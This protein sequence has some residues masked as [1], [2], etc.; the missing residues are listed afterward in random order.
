MAQQNLPKEHKNHREIL[1][2]IKKVDCLSDFFP[3][4]GGAGDQI[5]YELDLEVILYGRTYHHKPVGPYVQLL[6]YDPG[7][8]IIKQGDWADNYYYIVVDG[9]VE[10]ARRDPDGGE[11]ELPDL[12]KGEQFGARAM[13]AGDHYRVTV[14]A[15]ADQCVDILKVHRP[16]L[17]LLRKMPR[18]DETFKKSYQRH[19]LEAAVNDLMNKTRMGSELRDELFRIGS[20]KAFDKHHILFTEAT[21]SERLFLILEGWVRR[22]QRTEE[23]EVRDFLGKGYCLGLENVM[24]K[25]LYSATA[26]GRINVLEINLQARRGKELSAA[27]IPALK[28]FAAPDM[29]KAVD[30]YRP[31]M[32]QKILEAQQSLI[33]T[34]LVD[35][36]NLLIMDMD[37]CVRCGNCSMACQKVHGRSRLT[38]RGVHITRIEPAKLRSIQS[39]LAPSACMHCNDPECLMGCPTGAISRFEG[40]EIDIDRKTCIGCGDCATQCPYDAIFMINRNEPP[41]P[42]PVTLKTRLWSNLAGFREPEAPPVDPAKDMIAVKC[43]LCSDRKTLNPNENEP[44]QHVYSC[45]EN[46]PTGA[47]ARIIPDKDFWEISRIRNLKMLDQKHA[48]GRSIH[49]ADPAKRWIHAVCI[50]VFMLAAA[51]AILGLHN[52]GYGQRVLGFLNMRWITG[53]AGLVGIG[54]AGAYCWRR[55]IYDKRRWPLRYW[56]LIHYYFGVAACFIILLH[57]GTFSGGWLTTLLMVSFDVV[58][59]TGVFGLACYQIIPR[60]LTRIEGVPLLLEDLKGRREELRKELSEIIRKSPEHLR[61]MLTRRVSRRCNSS[62]AM[63]HVLAQES[64]GQLLRSMTRQSRIVDEQTNEE[65]RR[66]FNEAMQAAALLPRV[67]ALIFLHRVL[68]IWIRPHMVSAYLMVPLMVV[69]IFQVIYAAW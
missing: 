2:A 3:N 1:N 44:E 15:P 54:G 37:L 68:S 25:Y 6:T 12:N 60:L 48:Y 26:L 55:T 30:E 14:K 22:S 40:G 21:D 64:L 5:N 47:L 24:S 4:K 67:S 39:L 43:N 50:L 27:L 41:K 38:R 51:G 56:A 32:R 61:P 8:T 17:R 29:E 65:D 53:L 33:K 57:G 20:F 31:P 69:H 49:K 16:A 46:C 19:G 34:G 13:L 35:A 66:S 9:H 18:F 58:V 42:P 10:V 36:N 62:K 52:Y 7:Q 45:E 11:P 28:Q 23:Q 63:L 59:I